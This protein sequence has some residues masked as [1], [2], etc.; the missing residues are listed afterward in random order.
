VHG[1][2]G[3]ADRL[4]EVATG[5]I[6]WHH[7]SLPVVPLR[8]SPALHQRSLRDRIDAVHR[9]A[10][11]RDPTGGFRPRAFLRTGSDVTA[12]GILS[13]FV[14]R[15]STEV[16]FAETGRHLGAEKTLRQGS[17]LAIA[18]TTPALLGL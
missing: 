15:W 11:V 5:T 7:P 12:A 13:W 4:V 18:R 14:R 3:G 6:V 1:W 17:G 10:L 8:P 9:W 2:Y 16:T